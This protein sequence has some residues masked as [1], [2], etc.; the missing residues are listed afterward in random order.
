MKKFT[1]IVA[2]VLA[3]VAVQAQ[4]TFDLD[5]AIGING[6]AASLTIEPGDTVRW[7]WDDGAPH[8][9]TSIA[10]QSV[11][12]FDSGTLTGIG[13]TFEFTFN[14]VGVNDYRCEIHP[15]TMFGTITVEPVLA[16]EDKFA[17][18]INWFPNP[19]Q[20]RLNITSLFKLDGYA[21][22]NMA[23]KQIMQGKDAGNVLQL[24]M[25]SLTSG[26]YFVGLTSGDLETTLRVVKQ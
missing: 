14:T 16:I 3:S 24:D 21:V 15:G 7:T 9:V 18:N 12:S 8:T 6:S 26:I 10:G 11:E 25:S 19:V 23:G 4:T 22:Y 5:W 20:E 13:Q 2:A 17:I 1:I